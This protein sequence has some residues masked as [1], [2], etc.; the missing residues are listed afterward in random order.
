LIAPLAGFLW[1]TALGCAQSPKEGK[2]RLEEV[3]Q[4]G[5]E[6]SAALDVLEER[7]LGA[8]ANLELWQEMARR[9]QSV[10]AIACGNLSNHVSGMVRNQERQ[11][12][13]SRNLRRP[14]ASAARAGGGLRGG[15]ARLRD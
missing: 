9:H 15:S 10:S 12:E 14:L 13:K 2:A 1:L 5:V 8:Q 6:M 7:L 3:N 4:Q 11:A